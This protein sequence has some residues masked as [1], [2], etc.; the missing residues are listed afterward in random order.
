MRLNIN[1][2]YHPQMTSEKKIAILI[3]D[4]DADIRELLA[5]FLQQHQFQTFLAPNG[6]VMQALLKQHPIDLI[7]LDIMM[8]GTDGLTLCRELRAQSNI[9]ILMLTAMG[10]EVDRIV[11]LEIGADDYL[12]K[13]FSPRELLARIKAILRRAQNPMQKT[14]KKQ[15]PIY[16]FMGWTLDTG[17]RRLIAPDQLEVS[18]SAGEYNLLLVFL[19]HPQQ[20]LSRDQ[21]LH[22]TKSRSAGPFDRSIDIQ[23]SRLRYKIEEDT[24]N[25]SAIKTVRGG[26]YI[27]AIPVKKN[28]QE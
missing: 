28:D 24:K 8:P 14:V 11:G 4:D 5:K 25:P 27:L 21:L 22:Y 17:T 9:P 26:G 1:Q 18:I 10:E 7:I 3:V 6:T 13:P 15:N 23:I 19:T 2:L 12:H 16:Y 20:V